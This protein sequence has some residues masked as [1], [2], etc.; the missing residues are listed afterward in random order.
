M[1]DEVTVPPSDGHVAAVV[2][3]ALTAAPRC[4]DVVVVAVDGPS[5]AGKTTL[6]RGVELALAEEGPDGGISSKHLQRLDVSRTR[7]ARSLVESAAKRADSWSAHRS[8]C[9]R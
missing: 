1:W 8:Q 7:S 6:A 9:G 2:S 5:G 3:L 4:G